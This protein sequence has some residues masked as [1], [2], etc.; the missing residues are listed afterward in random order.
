MKNKLFAFMPLVLLAATLLCSC[1]DDDSGSSTKRGSGTTYRRS[2]LIYLA[3]QNSLGAAGAQRL[4]SIEIANGASRLTNEL[5][6]VFLFIDDAKLPRLY[7]IYKNGKSTRTDKVLTWSTDVNSSDPAT[8]CTTLEFIRKNYPSES[9]GLV[10]WSHGNGWLA[11]TNVVNTMTKSSTL[12]AFGVDVGS[13]GDMEDDKTATG[14]PGAQMDI[15]DMAQAIDKS[16]V[17]LDFIFF[18]AC[19]MQGIEVAYELKD[20]TDYVVGSAISTSA[21]GAYYTNFIPKAL[22]AYPASDAN[23][24]LLANQY[25][26]DAAE[27]P[28]LK[29]YYGSTGCVNSAIKTSGLRELAQT[30]APLIA[31]TFAG[32]ATPSLDQIQAYVPVQMVNSPDYFDMGS[33]MKNLLS[34]SDYQA[35]LQ[36]ANKCVIAHNASSSFIMVYR[37]D[38]PEVGQIS[39]PESILG[40]SMFIPRTLFY[41]PPYHDYNGQFH[42]TLWYTDAGW[43]ETGW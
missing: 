25:Y 14:K 42:S 20:V 34:D 28:D 15:S 7:C 43:S 21:Y 39:D 23:I 18:D 2:V 10:L 40:V 4:D 33:A 13:D 36:V 12:R 26:Y 3:A 11:S 41:R 5:D 29:K 35:W 17:H 22:F 9:Y 24:A 37:N 30:T 38:V 6:N 31:K 19:L 8:L 27:N 16:G 32:K 1:S